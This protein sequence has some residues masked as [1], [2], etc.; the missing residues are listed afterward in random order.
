MPNQRPSKSRCAFASAS[1][2]L[3]LFPA[4][5]VLAS[6]GAGGGPDAVSAVTQLAVALII[7]GASAVVISAGLIDALRDQ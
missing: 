3:A 2:A 6:Q 1:T 7:Y 4:N 5:H